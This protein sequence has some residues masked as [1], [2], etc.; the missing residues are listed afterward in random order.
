MAGLPAR[1]LDRLQSVINAAARLIYRSRKFDHVTP[2]LNDLTGCESRN[3]SRFGSRFWCM[4]TADRMDLHHSTLLM[5]F[6]RW[7]RLSPGDGFVQRRLRHWSSHI[8]PT[9]RSTIGDRALS[10][11]AA[12]AWNSLPLSVTSSASVPVVRKRLKTVLVTRSFPS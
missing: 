2:L 9:A 12:R 11:A 8:P 3:E 5:T 7:R 6:T 1:Q 4:C 10:V